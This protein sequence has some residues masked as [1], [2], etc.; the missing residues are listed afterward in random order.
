M[1]S[2][3]FLNSSTNLRQCPFSRHD[4]IPLPPD[5]LWKIT[6]G[7]V[8]TLTWNDQGSLTALGYWGV[9]DLVGQP[10]SCIRPYQIECLTS[11]E[12]HCVAAHQYHQSLDAILSHTQ[13]TEELLSI[14]HQ[15]RV[16]CRLEQFLVWLARKFGRPVNSG[17]LIDLRLTHQA[18]AESVGT[19][20]V[21]VTRLLNQ[22][23]KEGIISRP[24]RHFIV[25]REREAEPLAHRDPSPALFGRTLKTPTPAATIK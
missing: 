1:I 13:Q 9:G 14:I 24:K 23:E 6:R 25:L 11:V 2:T 22:F 8:R 5:A 18:I 21:T 17:Q 12:V 10:L 19:T 15:E 7:V 16:H 3:H 20:R 4:L